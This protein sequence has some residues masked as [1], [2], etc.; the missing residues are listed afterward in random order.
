MLIAQTLFRRDDVRRQVWTTITATE[1]YN[2]TQFVLSVVRCEEDERPEVYINI[3][4]MYI[5]YMYFQNK[6]RPF[7]YIRS[8][9]M[10]PYIETRKELLFLI[11]LLNRFTFIRLFPRTLMFSVT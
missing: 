11:I 9:K 1:R 6:H 8:G 5:N 2:T 3:I 4:N 7:D 10:S